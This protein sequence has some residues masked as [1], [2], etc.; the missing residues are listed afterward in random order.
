MKLIVVTAPGAK[1]KIEHEQSPYCPSDQA[2]FL[3]DKMS[4]FEWARTI[5]QADKD[6]NE[7]I[8]RY[9]NMYQGLKY[10]RNRALEK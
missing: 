5:A 6:R 8:R 2:F 3:P 9:E 10:W 7:W 1:I 4:P